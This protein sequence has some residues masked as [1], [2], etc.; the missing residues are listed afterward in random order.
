MIGVNEIDE[1]DELY[2]KKIGTLLFGFIAGIVLLFFVPEIG[3]LLLLASVVEFF[4]PNSMRAALARE[5]RNISTMG[6]LEVGYIETI[7]VESRLLLGFSWWGN[8]VDIETCLHIPKEHE[9]LLT[10]YTACSGGEYSS[11]S[12]KTSV[13]VRTSSR[14]PNILMATVPGDINSA[15]RYV[16]IS[17]WRK[18]LDGDIIE[19]I[20]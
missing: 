8:K 10:E 6:P 3:A 12:R 20:E 19:K 7:D 1:L 5:R 16:I 9:I 15:R 14:Y 11:Y 18:F 2:K 4:R 17:K 13:V